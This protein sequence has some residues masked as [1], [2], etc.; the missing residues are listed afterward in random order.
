METETYYTIAESTE[1]L[2][3]S[4]EDETVAG[5]A[6]WEDETECR[7]YLKTFSEKYKIIKVQVTEL[8]AKK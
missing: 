7:E 5:R 2:L 3:D 6:F 1:D 8:P 4:L